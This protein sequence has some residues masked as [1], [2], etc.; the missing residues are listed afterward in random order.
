MS[1]K[2]AC[3]QC[4]KVVCSTRHHA[5]GEPSC[6]TIQHAA[7]ISAAR[8]EYAKPDIR[9]FACQAMRQH[10]E[11]VLRLP[12][13]GAV[14]RN[15][16]IEE[17]ARFAKK[18]GYNKLGIAFCGALREAAQMTDKILTN[19]GFDVVSI[20]CTAGGLPIETVGI[21]GEE[22]IAGPEV[23]Q[24]MCNPIMQAEILNHEA[25]EFNILVGL[26]VGH[27]SLFFKYARAPSTVLIVKDRVFGHN[28]I[29]ALQQAPT[30]YRWLLRRE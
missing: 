12:E 25:V 2:T 27:D 30:F 10:N 17:V 6:P 19:R 21:T 14:P 4:Q 5:K 16:R 9:A 13:G 7:I 1:E 24:S 20:C 3:T 28:P 26:C 15:P 29:A 8:E 23:W 11:A 22:K 18:M